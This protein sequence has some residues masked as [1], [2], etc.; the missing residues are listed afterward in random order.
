MISKNKNR[1]INHDWKDGVHFQVSDF[2]F[3]SI[4]E[5]SISSKLFL[6]HSCSIRLFVLLGEGVLD[7]RFGNHTT[8]SNRSKGIKIR[9]MQ[10][11]KRNVDFVVY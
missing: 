6:N 5:I 8:M 11:A 1:P 7:L 9:M 3:W 4:E 10:I 2:I